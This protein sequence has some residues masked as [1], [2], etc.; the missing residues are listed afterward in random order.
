MDSSSTFWEDYYAK[1]R[2]PVAPSFFAEFVTPFLEEGKQ[3]IDLG[4]GNGRDSIHFAKHGISVTAIDQCS[5]ELDFLVEKFSELDTLNI[6]SADM[7][8]MENLSEK[9]DYLYSRFTIHAVDKNGQGR[10]LDWASENTQQN[11]LFFIEVRST[12][13]EL[14]GQGEKLADNAFF[15]DHYRRF[16]VIDELEADLKSRGFTILYS[17]ESNGCA[18]HGDADP[19]VIRLIAQ[20]A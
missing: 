17:L 1:H 14:Y 12:K 16:I 18:P 20:K 5:Q 8:N 7:T 11:G 9:A 4:C 15:T 13:D 3:L 19:I 2:T 10:L 6:S